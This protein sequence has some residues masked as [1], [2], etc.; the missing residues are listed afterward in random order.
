ML[1]VSRIIPGS[2]AD[3]GKIKPG[4]ELLSINGHPVDD[5]IDY[6]FHQAEYE[7]ALVFIRNGKKYK[8]ELIKEIDQRLGL[9][10]HPDKIIRCNNNCIFCF[11]YNNP[12]HLRRSLY[13]RDDDYRH[14]FIYGSFI[15]L[16]NLSEHDIDR[17][18][19]MRLSPLYISVHATDLST[20]RKLFGRKNV[21]DI[22]PILQKLAANNIYFHCQIVIT[23]GFNDNNIL[24]KT[25][26]DLA[27]LR[28]FALSMA[29]VPVG[30]TKYSRPELKTVGPKRA[31]QL[32]AKTQS[33]R[34][35]YGKK[36][37]RFAYAADELFIKAGE[38]IPSSD[39]YDD[40][41]QIENGVGMVRDF[42]DSVPER[43]PQKISGCWITGKSMMQVWRKQIIPKK[44]IKIKLIPVENTLFGKKVTVTGLLPGRDVINRLS[45][46]KLNSEPIIL[47]PNC[48]NNDN[49]FIDDLTIEDIKN[50]LGNDV[51]QGSYSFA[52]T[53]RM[54]S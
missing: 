44:N 30:L 42:L 54:V 48:L 15:T 46:L 41:P 5:L 39:Y 20:R 8:V 6:G 18:I 11:C 2:P 24:D 7:I 28:P 1:K 32:I 25:T 19:K 53:L 4:D 31:A 14:S 45:K 22:L 34:K 40:F 49:L 27:E 38:K 43:M 10:F 37:N 50:E 13:I 12:K 26:S 36:G 51:I 21:K 47:P 16:T 3:I 35:K 17:I 52:E 23:P 9:E 29:I 33:F